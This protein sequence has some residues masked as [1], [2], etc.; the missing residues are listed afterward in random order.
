MGKLRLD[1]HLPR[2][3]QLERDGPGWGAAL[4]LLSW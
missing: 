1:S 2:A 4:Q 3:F